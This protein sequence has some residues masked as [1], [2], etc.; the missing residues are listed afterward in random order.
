MAT[1][2]ADAEQYHAID[3]RAERIAR[4]YAESLY[5]AAPKGQA[6]D[7]G[8]ELAE[9]VEGAFQRE[10]KLE[11]LFSIATIA[12]KRKAVV[13]EKDFR[14]RASDTFVNFLHVL[15]NHLRLDLLRAI[16][17]SYRELLDEKKNRVRVLV[18]SAVPLDD[19]QRER[20]K[21]DVR[22]LFKLDPVVTE[23]IDQSLLG[24]MAVRVGDWQFDGTLRAR[25]NNLKNQLLERSSYEIQ[26]RRDRFST[27]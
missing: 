8:N 23:Q 25:L 18:R 3:V 7:I 14:G 4:V 16:L 22:S 10:P 2:I 26:S 17:Y 19:Q 5:D 27:L 15:N 24:G 6:E 11:S 12:A 21:T 1:P 9:L 13:I 20:L